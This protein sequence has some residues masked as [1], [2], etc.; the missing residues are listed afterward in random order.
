MIEEENSLNEKNMVGVNNNNGNGRCTNNVRGTLAT[1]LSRKTAFPNE[2]G[3]LPIGEF[4][5]RNNNSD[6]EEIK[7]HKILVV[8]AGGLGKDVIFG[9]F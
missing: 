3:S 4:E 2:T 9:L 6:N 7:K 1:L 5:V 8:G